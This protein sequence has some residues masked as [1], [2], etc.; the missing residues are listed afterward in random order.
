[1]KILQF[2]SLFIFILIFLYPIEVQHWSVIFFFLIPFVFFIKKEIKIPRPSVLMLFFLTTLL[3]LTLL[4]RFTYLS[5]LPLSYI[6]LLISFY[7]FTFQIDK[8]SLL[9]FTVFA[10][11][12]AIFYGFYQ[13]FF[14][15][16]NYPISEEEL[17]GLSLL[18]RVR[19]IERL[20]EERIFSLFPLPTSFCFFLSI[21][22]LVSI[23]LALSEK[24]LRA[25]IFYSS[26][27][28]L[29]LILMIFTKSFGGIVGLFGGFFIFLFIIGKKDLKILM[30]LL[31]ISIAIISTIFYLR[32][33]TLSTK[34]PLTLRLSNWKIAL[35][36]IS[37]HPFFGVGL[38][39]YTSFSLPLAR[40]RSEAT[41]YA[42]NFF[43]QFF[44]ETG[45]FCFMLMILTIF[46]WFFRPFKNISSS[47]LEAS[48][49]GA[50]FSILFYNLIDIGISFESFG[51]LT[52]ILF[53]FVEGRESCFK[54]EG[55][56]LFIFTLFFTVFLLFPL[57]TYI[58]EELVQNANLNM[59]I[60]I[61]SSEKKLI[62]ARK[63]NPFNP[64]IYSYLS[65]MESKKGNLLSSLQ[66]I[67]KSIS[68]Y[69][70]SHSFYFEKSV[71]LLKMRRYLEAYL[72]LREAEKLNPTFVP[73]RDERKKLEDFLFKGKND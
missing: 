45:I 31:I 14:L 51:F 24:K 2:L 33:D 43:L 60:D 22:F 41:K 65:F 52:I 35:K 6:V 38:N 39:N 59:G 7:I 8:S 61:S 55:R 11:L 9:K 1:M 27:T 36:V 16:P 70:Y 25:R 57:W 18:T 44:A 64:K 34:N 12:P 69:P 4:N 48:V 5:L 47:S 3:V 63:I 10:S 15:F 49:W 26:I 56:N 20:K 30:V 40:E 54:I 23:G 13:K 68:L 58:T 17:E 32:L 72:S 19:I 53:S 73:Y 50:L 28:L 42:H 66:Y 46:I 37:E 21:I 29:S 71:I 62:L 67:E